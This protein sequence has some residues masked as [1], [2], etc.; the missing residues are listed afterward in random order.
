MNS[1]PAICIDWCSTTYKQ[2][3]GIQGILCSN[4]IISLTTRKGDRSQIGPSC[5]TLFKSVKISLIIRVL[6]EE[7]GKKREGITYKIEDV[8]PW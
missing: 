5:E 8:P 4:L 1:P 7:A 2:E 6:Q 3:Y